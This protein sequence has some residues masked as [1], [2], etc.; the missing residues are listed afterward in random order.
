MRSALPATLGGNKLRA[1]P[2]IVAENCLRS[3]RVAAASQL[4]FI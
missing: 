4:S 2:S 1:S 3:E